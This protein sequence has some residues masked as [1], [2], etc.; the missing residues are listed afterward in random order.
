MPYCDNP[1]GGISWPNSPT[2]ARSHCDGDLFVVTRTLELPDEA[3][4]TG[5]D[6]KIATPVEPMGTL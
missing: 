2:C 5:W 6:T 3:P 1:F 4:Y